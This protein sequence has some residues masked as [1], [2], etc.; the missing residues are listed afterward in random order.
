MFFKA[1]SSSPIN[2]P[3]N[4]SQGVK[5]SRED[6]R[7]RSVQC[8]KISQTSGSLQR[9]H[10]VDTTDSTTSANSLPPKKWPSGPELNADTPVVLTFPPPP[11][12]HPQQQ[13][14]GLL[15]GSST[16]IRMGTRAIRMS[17]ERDLTDVSV[18]CE[19]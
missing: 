18:E 19:T 9:C 6:Y 12:A 14:D 11:A 5:S 17:R 10:E 3:I 2:Q 15:G 4:L 7:S 16:N 1:I 13:K 8:R